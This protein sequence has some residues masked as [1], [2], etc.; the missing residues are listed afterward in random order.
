MSNEVTEI[1]SPSKGWFLIYQAED[2]ELKVNVRFNEE[3]VWVA[4]QQLAARAVNR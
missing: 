4:Q 1:S 3:L 2:G